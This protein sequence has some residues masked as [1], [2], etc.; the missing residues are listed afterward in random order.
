MNTKGNIKTG[1]NEQTRY[2]YQNAQNQFKGFLE[3]R[4]Y[5]LPADH[6]LIAAYLR[7][8]IQRKAPTSIPLHLS[9]IAYLYR[10]RH[11]PID[12]RNPII[13]KVKEKA[14]KL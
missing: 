2:M 4:G 11:W 7:T 12:V 6:K 8:L 14:K 1:I 13:V 9:A 5:A 3:E 10:E